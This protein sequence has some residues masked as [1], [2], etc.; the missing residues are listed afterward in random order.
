MILF[1]R[2]CPN[3]IRSSVTSQWKTLANN[4]KVATNHRRRLLE[5]ITAV[6]HTTRGN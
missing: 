4:S 3:N 6:I 1:Q 5:K 2:L